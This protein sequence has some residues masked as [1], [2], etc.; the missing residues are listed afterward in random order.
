MRILTQHPY[1]CQSQ[2][3]FL[4]GREMPL[5]HYDAHAFARHIRLVS[6][7]TQRPFVIALDGRS[8]VGKSTLALQMTDVLGAAI[9]DG[10]DFFAG[11]TA[12][13]SDAPALRAADCI[14]WTHQR[15]VLDVLRQGRAA[16]WR[17]FDWDAFDGRLQSSVTELSPRSV[18]ILEG[19]YSARP[20][21]ADLIDMKVLVTVS[22]ALRE[23]RLLAR[24][25]SIDPW[26]RQW[27]EAEAHYFNEVMPWGRFEV[28]LDAVN[29]N[30]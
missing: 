26:E 12:L 14:D 1:H 6:A 16:S 11:G 24:E 13:R 15:A 25:G 4:I 10:D 19:V 29:A 23:A 3:P 7:N 27:H 22:D 8:G 18:V 21:L 5:H 30:E 17:A 2:A 20:E 9:I 28:I